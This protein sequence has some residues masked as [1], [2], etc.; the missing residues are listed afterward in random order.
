MDEDL[1]THAAIYS[2]NYVSGCFRAAA[3]I[4]GNDW[5]DEIH[6]DNP[7][8]SI[9]TRWNE[10]IN[11]VRTSTDEQFKTNIEQYFNLDSLI[12]YYIF[13]YAICGLDILGKNQMYLTYDGSLFYASAYDLDSTWGLY[14]NGRH[15]VSSE[16][17]MQEDYE[18]GVHNTSNL[19]Y[20]R[21]ESLFS[22]EIKSRY[23]ELRAGVL[24]IAYIKD[25]FAAWCDISSPELMA[26]DY[27]PETGN[28]AF[29]SMPHAPDGVE[30]NY[31]QIVAY[32]EARLAYVD[33]QIAQL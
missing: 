4:D 14:Y 16:Y 25:Q 1:D 28:G 19:L 31:Q 18:V 30:N 11:F 20:D 7:P 12:D 2:E 10:V 9:V 3:V 29:V 22:D 5:T 24:S 13:A 32:A 6:E 23:A 26:L 8:Q 33:A 21:I 27:A 17:R 15:Y